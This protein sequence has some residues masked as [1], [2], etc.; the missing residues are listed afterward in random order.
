MHHNISQFT[1]NGIRGI[2]KNL[3]NKHLSNCAIDYKVQP[4]TGIDGKYQLSVVQ[5][6]GVAR[7]FLWGGGVHPQKKF[8]NFSALKNCFRL[9]LTSLNFIKA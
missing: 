6:S 4:S 1:K 5:G 2:S 7:N 8:I 9:L 3:K